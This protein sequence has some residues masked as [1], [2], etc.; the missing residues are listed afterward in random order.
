MSSSHR[1]VGRAAWM[2][3]LLVLAV[4][5]LFQA[6]GAGEALR[7]ERGLLL[8][9]PWRIVTSHLVHLGWVHLGLNALAAAMLGVAIGRAM[10]PPAWL[11]SAA[12][13]V[14]AVSGGLAMWSPGVEWYMG[15]S[16]VLHG[17]LAAGAI[18]GLRSTPW[19]S[20]MLLLALAGKL[21]FERFATDPSPVS[22]LI[23]GAVVTDAHFYGAL[24]G[25]LAGLVI[26]VRE[27]RRSDNAGA[28]GF[29]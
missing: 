10:P 2:V 14:V 7:W 5:V 12:V 24:G 25:V 18:A 4:A 16:G 29:G 8:A 22:L 1:T 17:L 9:E 15:F 13:S 27:R 19:V 6:L 11:W 20:G 26:L 21:S 23:G 3:F 28:A